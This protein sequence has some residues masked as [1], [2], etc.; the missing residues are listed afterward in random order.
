MQEDHLAWARNFHKKPGVGSFL[1]ACLSP[2][3][4]AVML[5]RFARWFF[6]KGWTLISDILYLLTL[7]LTGAE[8]SPA[9]DVGG[10]LV[11]YHSPATGLDGKLGRNVVLTSRV[12]IGKNGSAVDIGAGPWRPI[13]GNNIY[14]GSNAVVTGPRRV[15]DNVRF[16]SHCFVT[17]DIPSGA[18]V[19]GIPARVMNASRLARKNVSAPVSAGE[20][21]HG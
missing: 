12:V 5:H 10:G 18:D 17:R 9:S 14:I 20:V 16:Y 13:L 15:G 7:V 1:S 2:G 8:I 4:I 6:L 19:V 3:F 21:S 11:I